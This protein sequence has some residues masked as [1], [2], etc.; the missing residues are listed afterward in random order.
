MYMLNLLFEFNEVRGRFRGDRPG[1]VLNTSLNWL[2]LLDPEP[3]NPNAP[4]FDPEAANWNNLGQAGTL[5]IPTP[6]GGGQENICI[7]VRQDPNEVQLPATARLQLA[8]G[9]GRAV[10]SGQPQSSPFRDAQVPAAAKT[11]IL[12]GAVAKTTA[13]AWYFHLGAV[14]LRPVTRNVTHRYEFSVGV[15]VDSAPNTAGNV[16]RHYGEDPEMDIG[17]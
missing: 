12:S 10:R 1:G 14:D 17:L 4:P 6:P 16:T 3:A 9:F 13:V 8:A 15:I 5:L 11:T 7:R 2:Q